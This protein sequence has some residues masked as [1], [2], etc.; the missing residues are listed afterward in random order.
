MTLALSIIIPTLNEEQVLGKTLARLGNEKNCE[1]I[2][3]DGGSSDTTLTLAEKT[4]CRTISS[5]KGRGRQMN[6]GAAAARGEVLLFLHADTLL[7]DNF[8]RLIHDAVR[9][10]SFAA[11]AFSLAID[12]PARSLATIAWFA[13]LRSRV[14]QLPYGDQAFFVSKRM[15]DAIGG[16]P[17][18]AIMEDFVF[19]RKIKE[20]GKIIILPERVI[21]SARRWQNIGIVRTTLINQAIVCGHGLGVSPATLAVWYRRMRGVDRQSQ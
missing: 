6:A 14:L 17:E 10:P 1:V 13:N 11:G 5:A 8:C 16:F 19:I 15:F 2:V 4:G 18:M 20:A 7:P 21:T 9:L 12:S 3:V